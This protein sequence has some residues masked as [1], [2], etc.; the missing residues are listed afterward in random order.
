MSKTQHLFSQFLWEKEVPM[1]LL[2]KSKTFSLAF[3]DSHSDLYSALVSAVMYAIS[4]YIGPCYNS[5]QLYMDPIYSSPEINLDFNL[6]FEA[7]VKVGDICAITMV[8]THYCLAMVV[9]LVVEGPWWGHLLGDLVIELT[10]VYK[11]HLHGGFRNG[12]S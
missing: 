9:T 1:Y 2:E 3:F 10:Q 6:D 5:T 8:D 7:P 11:L 4:C 12:S